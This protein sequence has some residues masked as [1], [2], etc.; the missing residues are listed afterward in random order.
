MANNYKTTET[1]SGFKSPV[2][3]TAGNVVVRNLYT[4][5]YSEEAKLMI[6]QSR[7]A[8]DF[9]IANFNGSNPN[10]IINKRRD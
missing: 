9:N 4:N 5:F 3:L 1:Q 2:Q 6:F 7:T 8:G 10:H